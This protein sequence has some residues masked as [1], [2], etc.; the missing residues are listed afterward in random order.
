M[1]LLQLACGIPV[2]L[3]LIALVYSLLKGFGAVMDFNRYH[4][5]VSGHKSGPFQ[6]NERGGVKTKLLI[7]S[8]GVAALITA[9]APVQTL[10]WIS[11]GLSGQGSPTEEPMGAISNFARCMMAIVAAMC[12][13]TVTILKPK[14]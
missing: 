1:Q 9:M 11:Q 8:L 10:L 14:K 13:L 12:F 3:V 2:I 7:G 6:K 5:L 4:T